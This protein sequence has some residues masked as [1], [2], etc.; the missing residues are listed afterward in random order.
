[1]KLNG[2]QIFVECL[3]EQGVDVV[4]GFPG[5]KVIFLYDELYRNRDSIRH[6][7][8]SHEQGAAHAADGYARSTGKVGVC[9]ATSGPGATNLVTGIATAYM[10]SVPIVAFTGQVAKHELGK[11]S[12]QEV[13]IT[14]IT[15]PI[16][17]HNYIIK[18]VK[19]LAISI[20]EAFAIAKEGRPGPVLV[21][22]CVD[23]T[24]AEWEYEK[25]DV[26]K[27]DFL[28]Q[29]AGIRHEKVCESMLEEAAAA[30]NEAKRPFLISGGGVTISGCS[31][32]VKKL[33]RKARIPVATTLMGLGSF[34]SGDNLYTG[35]IGMHGHKASNLAVSNCDLL[36]AVGARFS[37]RVTSNLKA[38][39]PE[40]KIIHI[41]IDSAEINKNVKVTYPLC[42]YMEQILE[43]LVEMVQEKTE[44]SWLEEVMAWKGKYPITYT[45]DSKTIKPQNVIRS[46]HKQTQGKAIVVT[47]V[48]QNQL[49]AAQWFKYSYPRQFISSG[50]LGTMGY[51]LGAAIGAKIGNPDKVVVD[52]AGDG[53]FRM[54]FNEIA[55]AVRCKIPVIVAILN[56][57]VLGMVR[58][59]QTLFLENRYSETDISDDLDFVA[60]AK[61]MGA[62][63]I[64]VDNPEDVDKAIEKALLVTDRPVVMDFRIDKDEMVY[65]IVPPGA[66]IDD[67]ITE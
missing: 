48:G 15:I 62:E 59:W 21:D 6:I 67:L 66:S 53:S 20:R 40:A 58:Q 3:K 50:G 24:K 35:L 45:E 34:P 42:G 63:G 46:F 8:T 56:N 28:K 52:F 36:I 60:L 64:R 27:E 29:H 65:P 22:I 4:F 7:L 61:A 32:L 31:E 37:D 44:G 38:F 12:F 23:V 30:I 49:W 55:T 17:K 18:E 26:A 41:D 39:A 11:D 54:N 2:S 43:G 25:V 5:G 57:G 19:D 47:E 14:G 51:G 16:T 13:D 9:I 33:S 10:D 1:M